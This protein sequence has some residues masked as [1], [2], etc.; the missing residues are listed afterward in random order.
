MGEHAPV[1]C[2]FPHGFCRQGATTKSLSLMDHGSLLSIREMLHWQDVRLNFWVASSGQRW[3]VM[4]QRRTLNL[5]RPTWLWK[6]RIWKPKQ[7]DCGN[8]RKCCERSWR[9][10]N[11]SQKL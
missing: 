6:A 9:Q 1:V 7:L 11:S 5:L 10:H 3:S 8:L 4:L 2:G